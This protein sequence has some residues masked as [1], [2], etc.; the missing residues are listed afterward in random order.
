ML[1]EEAFYDCSAIETIT[2][3]SQRPPTVNQYALEGLKYSTIVYVPADYVETYKMHDAWG[4]YDV[5]PLD[6]HEDIETVSGKEALTTE[7]LYRNGQVFIL[8]GDK[9]YTLQGQEIK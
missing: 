9:T 2:C 7:K 4:L 3:Y 1:E 8:R 5:R 6:A